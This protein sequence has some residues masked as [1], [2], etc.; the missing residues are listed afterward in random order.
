MELFD[1]STIY[2]IVPLII[3][4]FFLCRNEA[5]RH[6][7]T[8]FALLGGFMYVGY[9]YGKTDIVYSIYSIYSLT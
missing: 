3:W 9:L 5:L 8:M 1:V 2:C 6:L 4:L 7:L